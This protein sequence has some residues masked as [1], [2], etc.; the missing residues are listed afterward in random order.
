MEQVL[1]S[2]SCF[3]STTIT[4][5]FTEQTGRIDMFPGIWAGDRLVLYYELTV[6]KRVTL[7]L[8]VFS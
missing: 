6:P 2:Y 8:D 3:N 4:I 1:C 7:L 5:L